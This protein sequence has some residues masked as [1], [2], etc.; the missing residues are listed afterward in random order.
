MRSA[1]EGFAPHLLL[2]VLLLLDLLLYPL[3]RFR[4]HL[5]TDEDGRVREQQWLLSVGGM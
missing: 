3:A 4:Y 2:L 5:R 1:A